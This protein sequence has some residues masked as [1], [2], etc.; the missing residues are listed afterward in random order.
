MTLSG[1]EAFIELLEQ[2]CAGSSY[3]VLRGDEHVDVVPKQDPQFRR[4][5]AGRTTEVWT[6]RIT[7]PAPGTFTMTDRI[8]AAT[9]GDGRLDLAA[10]RSIRT[11]RFVTKRKELRFAPAEDGGLEPVTTGFDSAADHR[12]IRSVA[13]ELGYAERMPASAR[14]GL[15]AAGAGIGVVVAMGVVAAA[16]KLLS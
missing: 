15:L 10:A 11:G 14:I 6:Y 1:N 9:W 4:L 3:E 16:I 13:A 2:R 5:N 7:F 8:V 12:V